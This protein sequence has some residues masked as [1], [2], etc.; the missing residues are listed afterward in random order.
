MRQDKNS[1]VAP[2]VALLSHE[3]ERPFTTVSSIKYPELVC[4]GAKTLFPYDNK[5]TERERDFFGTIKFRAASEHN[6]R[7]GGGQ[8]TCAHHV[9]IM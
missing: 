6:G 7:R 5:A 3:K 9:C 1:T 2:T 8:R 4:T